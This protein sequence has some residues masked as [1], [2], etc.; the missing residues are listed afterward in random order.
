[1][2]RDRFASDYERVRREAGIASRDF[3]PPPEPERSRV[4]AMNDDFQRRMMDREEIEAYQARMRKIEADKLTLRA[5][6]SLRQAE[7]AAAGVDPP[8]GFSASL[9]LL[10]QIG[11]TI[12]E[13]DGRKVLLRPVARPMPAQR[14]T[15]EELA[16]ESLK[17]EF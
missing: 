12:G 3:T 7:F 13:V 9:S 14:K 4:E 8:Q 15:R 5:N 10:L 6:D 16:A 17:E 2:K 1:M 11:W